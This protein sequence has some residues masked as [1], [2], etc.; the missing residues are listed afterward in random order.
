MLAS[1]DG[2]VQTI[3]KASMINPD[4]EEDPEQVI[5]TKKR[6][7]TALALLCQAKDTRRA[8]CFQS[9]LLDFLLH[10]IKENTGEIRLHCCSAIAALAKTEENREFIANKDDMVAELSS[11]VLNLN[12]DAATKEGG[13]KSS[14]SAMINSST[15]LNAC[16]ALLHLSKQCAVA[17]KMCKSENV[18]NVLSSCSLDLSDQ[19]HSRCMETIYH[20]SRFPGNTDILAENSAAMNAINSNC[21]S[22]SPEDRMWSLRAMQNISAYSNKRA[23]F[24]TTDTLANLCK[25]AQKMELVEEHEAAI[26]IIS[27]LCTD[28]SSAVVIVNAEMAVKVLVMVANDIDYSPE[29]Q[30]VACDALATLSMWLQRVARA[31]SVPENYSFEPLPTLKTT[32]YMRYNTEE[33]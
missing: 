22:F 32:G 23:M 16:A 28:P 7:L 19:V 5:V 25:S 26:S 30:V 8:I 29:I 1:T 14:N 9:G 6:L 11:L 27:N 4:L 15:R 31:A 33:L 24:A 3:L 13:K 2:L 12:P 10:N 17:A 21:S 20:L 18:L